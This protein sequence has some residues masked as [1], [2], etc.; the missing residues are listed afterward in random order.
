MKR[1]F[2]HHLKPEQPIK[3]A[4]G[5]PWPPTAPP[6]SARSRRWYRSAQRARRPSA[7]VASPT[8]SRWHVRDTR[9]RW[10]ASGGMC[11]WTQ[12]FPRSPST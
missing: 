9:M 5:Y 2:K 4:H 3:S 6:S 1:R 7:C 10:V 12:S 11:C 8:S